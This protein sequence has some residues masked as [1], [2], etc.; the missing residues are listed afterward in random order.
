MRMERIGQIFNAYASANGVN[1]LDCGT[2]VMGVGDPI[3]VG[4]YGLAPGNV[5]ATLTQFDYFRIMRRS[6]EITRY[7]P[8]RV[9]KRDITR[10]ERAT[11]IRELTR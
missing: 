10:T 2:A 11:A 9:R 7:R 8:I 1:W 3:S 5:P 6:K 4:V